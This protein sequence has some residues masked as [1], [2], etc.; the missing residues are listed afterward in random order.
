MSQINSLPG[1]IM[2]STQVQQRQA[3][4]RQRSIRRTQNLGKNSA[5]AGDQLE[6]Q[7][8]STDAAP[9]I[10]DERD[11]YQ[12]QR[13]RPVRKP[14]PRLDQEQGEGGLDLKA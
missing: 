8:E 2:Q 5:L 12:G 11:S 1:A 4:D 6:H 7:V 10:N 14:P 9:A 13:K 3:I